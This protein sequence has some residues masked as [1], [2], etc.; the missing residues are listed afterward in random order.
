[1]KRDTKRVLL[2]TSLCLLL[3]AC[4]GE[5]RAGQPETET[6]GS[7]QASSQTTTEAATTTGASGG[8]VSDLPSAEKEFV[9]NAGVLGLA[10][11]Q[12]SRMA[13]EKGIGGNV[14]AFAQKI[15]ADHSAS[16]AELAQL[17]TT[18]GLA[19]ATE[20]SGDAKA[21]LEHLDSL[22][23]ADFDRAFMQHMVADHEK[24]VADFD[25]ASTSTTDPQIKA[26]AVRNL[27]L[28]KQ[29]LAEAKD[30]ARRM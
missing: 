4:G 23:G 17:A 29:H 25:R 11:V 20:L 10:E 5:P 27:P 26:F 1:M 12:M 19:L 3:A 22:S 16:N 14:R 13:L 21:G 7:I 15:V 2:S 24:A 30:I 6:T 8:T 9:I 28:L 18:K